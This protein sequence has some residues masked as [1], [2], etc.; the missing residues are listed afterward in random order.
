MARTKRTEQLHHAEIRILTAVLISVQSDW[1]PEKFKNKGFAETM[2]Q[3]IHRGRHK[4]T[5]NEKA[6]DRRSEGDKE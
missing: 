3:E 4:N 1:F 6:G 5:R 2:K